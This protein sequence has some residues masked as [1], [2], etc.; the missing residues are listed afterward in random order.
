MTDAPPS[1]S[2]EEVLVLYGSQTGNSEAAAERIESVM[3][4]RLP[5]RTARLMQLDDFLEVHKANWTRLVVV[6]CSSYGV[7]QAPL[8]AR[9]FRELCD[10]VLEGEGGDDEFLKGI[11]FAL[12]GLGDS[13]YT[14]FFRNPTAIDD[15]L[16]RAGATRVGRLG[17]A[18]ASGTG[19][20]E[21]SASVDRW[22]EGIWDDLAKAIDDDGGPPEEGAL[23]R[24]REGTWRRCVRLNPE[25][26]DK[27]SAFGVWAVAAIGAAL[28][29][30]AS[31]LALS[32]GGE[33]AV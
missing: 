30:V 11:K 9:K 3:P 21:Q 32:G 2:S 18:D 8:G 5:G 20:E 13:H 25:W 10:A 6:V 19:D 15:A 22:I 1:P 14:T 12:L 17:K 24:A 27:K 16:T 33:G 28:A 4:S 26:E 23:E 31:Y 7:G 29:A